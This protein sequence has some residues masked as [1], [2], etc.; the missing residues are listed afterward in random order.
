MQAVAAILR[1]KGIQ[2]TSSWLNEH[3]DAGTTMDQIPPK[4]L[5]EFAAQDLADIVSADTLILF[6]MDP[7][8]PGV[9]GG[10][11]VEFGYALG[12]GKRIIVVGVK[13]NIFHYLL[14]VKHCTTIAELLNIIGV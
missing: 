11:H 10:R 6:S 12:R 1:A 4:E 2:V 7:M 3:W 13:E 8:I 5:S 9:R 14:R